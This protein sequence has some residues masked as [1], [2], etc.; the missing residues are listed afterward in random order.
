[1]RFESFYSSSTGNLYCVTAANGKRLL[2]ECGVT[3]RKLIKALS[4]D[5]TN[6]EAC[7]ISHEHL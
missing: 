7:L 1:M 5:L 6:I 3:W 2:I 4:Y